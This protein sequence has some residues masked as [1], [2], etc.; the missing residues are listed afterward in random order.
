[1]LAVN[2]KTEREGIHQTG[3]QRD[4]ILR[5]MP[6]DFPL[7][8][9]QSGDHIE[10]K[11]QAYSLKKKQGGVVKLRTDCRELVKNWQ[12]RQ[13]SCGRTMEAYRGGIKTCRVS[14]FL[15]LTAS[16][17]MFSWL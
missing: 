15:T 7:L 2:T 10:L 13:N 8:S 9:L 4:C 11:L 14:V 12:E 17:I 3:S 6:N 1:M 5:R 16:S